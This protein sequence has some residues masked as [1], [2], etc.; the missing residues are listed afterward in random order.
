MI[1]VYKTTNTINGMFYIG[2]HRGLES[3]AY[4]GSGIRL[5]R[6]IEKYGRENFTREIIQ[7]CSSIEEAY[8]L[9][10]ALVTPDLISS[11]TV[12]NLNTGG[13]GGWHH[14]IRRGEDNPA[15]RPEVRAKISSTHKE[16]ITQEERLRR[17][18]RMKLLRNNGTIIKPKGWSH[19]QEA[20]DK[21]SRSLTGRLAWNAGLTMPP[22]SEEVR[23]KKSESAKLRAAKQDMG[24]LTRGKK[25]KMNVKTCP[26]CGKIG[27]GGN[28][29]R[30]HFDN[31]KYGE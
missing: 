11:G 16:R 29:T 17:S 4:L 25:F 22:D 27:K 8:L 30:Y 10:K 20:R 24:A 26:I 15:K 14:A 1:F 31:C 9:E 21:I 7:V 28:M 18:E 6:A 19:T 2:V 13:H 23:M 5:K 3:D 12:Y